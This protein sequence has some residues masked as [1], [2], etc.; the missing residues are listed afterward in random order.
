[1]RKDKEQ[2][3]SSFR[4]RDLVQDEASRIRAPKKEF[5]STSNRVKSKII[6]IR[7]KAEQRDAL[8]ALIIFGCIAALIGLLL[9]LIG[10][11]VA[12]SS[13]GIAK[14]LFVGGLCIMAVGICVAGI[15]EPGIFF[16]VLYSVFTAL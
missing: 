16:D 15:A 8:D 6:S 1:M 4:L 14:T 7:Q 5:R 10:L 9:L 2:S 13:P 12:T 3:I 11:G